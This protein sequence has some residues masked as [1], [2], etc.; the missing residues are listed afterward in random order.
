MIWPV[1]IITITVGNTRSS[2]KRFLNHQPNELLP[3]IA[4]N[5]RINGANMIY[6]QI[7][8]YELRRRKKTRKIC[9]RRVRRRI[10]AMRKPGII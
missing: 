8:I 4:V 10:T 6:K 2:P 1:S 3:G 5:M 9:S 7:L